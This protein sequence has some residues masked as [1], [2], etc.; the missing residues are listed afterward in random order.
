MDKKFRAFS[1]MELIICLIAVC[2]IT[3]S[4][5]PIISKKFKTSGLTIGD[6][7]LSQACDK[8]TGCCT[9]CYPHKCVICEE[10]CANCASNQF[11]NKFD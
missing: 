10:E 1:I 7:G 2:A 4:F 11:L 5:T 8:F 9:L 6:S 3:V